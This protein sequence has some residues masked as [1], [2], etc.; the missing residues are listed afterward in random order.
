MKP[1]QRHSR[2]E[3]SSC[4]TASRHLSRAALAG[5]V[6]DGHAHIGI[7]VKAYANH[8]YPYAQTVEGLGYRMLATGVDAAVVFPWCP[9]FHLDL[10]AVARGRQRAAAKPL[11]PCPYALENRALLTEVFD[12]CPEWALRLLPFVC[13][14]PTMAVAQQVRALTE[15]MAQYPVYGI[16]ISP[17]ACQA[18]VAGLLQEG[19]A[20]LAFARARNLPFLL[21]TTGDANEGYSQPADAFR[22]IE[23]NPDL[24]FCL[25][26][27]ICFNREHLEHAAQLPNVWVDTAALK[28]QVQLGY[29][30]SPLMPTPAQLFATDYADHCQVM[31]DL[32]ARYPDKIVWGTDSPAYSFICRRQQASGHEA[33]FRLKAL[34]ED[35]KRALDGLRPALR[36]RVGNVNTLDFIFGRTE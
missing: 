20:L 10:N 33:I 30:R 28:I 17:V 13:A 35:E 3:R 8:E 9:E 25:A 22:F 14:H 32:A 15:L 31:R 4:R 5:K 2:R 19:R 36:R 27:G 34:Y 29:E 1:S 23:A 18:P 16:K 6:I 11:A 7:C 24:R 12:Y 21:H 26:H